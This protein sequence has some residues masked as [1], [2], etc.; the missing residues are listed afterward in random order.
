[1]SN[2]SAVTPFSGVFTTST[3]PGHLPWDTYNY[4]NAPHISAKHY[5]LPPQAKK[6]AKLVFV[7]VVQRHHKRTPDNLYPNENVFNP[8]A[9]WDCSNY[10]QISYSVGAKEDANLQGHGIYRKIENPSWHPLNSLIW[11]GTC[12]QGM[13]TADGL[14]DSIQHGRDFWSVY[15]PWGKNALLHGG[16]NK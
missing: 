8:P 6:D 13:L 3:T 4:C 5:E 10:Q 2:T 14:R 15:G 1:M 16:I 11:N 7:N 12:D 9:G